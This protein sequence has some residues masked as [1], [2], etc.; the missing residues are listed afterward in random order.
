MKHGL[1]AWR[2]EMIAEATLK[3]RHEDALKFAN[4]LK[5]RGMDINEI[6]EI[7]GLTIDEIIQL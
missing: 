1:A 2:D 6:A 3:T 4:A 5:V 7:T